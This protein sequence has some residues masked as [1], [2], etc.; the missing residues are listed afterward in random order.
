MPECSDVNIYLKLREGT[1]SRLDVRQELK[2]L[3]DYIEN[4]SDPAL[5]NL[6]C[7]LKKPRPYLTMRIIGVTVKFTM[8]AADNMEDTNMMR[9]IVAHCPVLIRIVHITVNALAVRCIEIPTYVIAGLAVF[10]LQVRSLLG[11]CVLQSLTIV[12]AHSCCRISRGTGRLPSR[13]CGRF[14]RSSATSILELA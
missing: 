2:A 11:H 13:F 1:L 10:F 3:S 8:D 6:Q 7:A 12:A 4:C 5:E 9:S 14:S